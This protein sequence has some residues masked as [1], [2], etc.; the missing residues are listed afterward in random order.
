M[1]RD[2]R[3]QWPRV[4]VEID[5]AHLGVH[6]HRGSLPSVL[7][8]DGFVDRRPCIIEHPIT[9]FTTWHS[10]Y[11]RFAGDRTQSGVQ[12]ARIYRPVDDPQYV[13]H[14]G[15]DT[16]DQAEA[17]EQFL[18]TRVWSTPAGSPA[19]VGTPV[20]RILQAEPVS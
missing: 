18:R 14:L 11:D 9:D 1:L 4:H 7:F 10:A 8:G 6:P 12:A 20:T 3:P 2:G 13:L 19:L 5:A 17:F 15:F 16:V